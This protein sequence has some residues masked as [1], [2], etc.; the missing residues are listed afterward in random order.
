MYVLAILIP[1]AL[2]LLFAAMFLPKK[3][4]ILASIIFPTAVIPLSIAYSLLSGATDNE[5]A[6]LFI[7]TQTLFFGLI[8][9]S[10]VGAAI[11]WWR[12]RDNYKS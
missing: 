3:R 2:A 6:W 7:F 4:A 1:Y 9:F 10:I 12:N 5:L 11:V 8:P